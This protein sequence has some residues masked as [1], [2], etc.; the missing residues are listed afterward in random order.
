MKCISRFRNEKKLNRDE[1][2]GRYILDEFKKLMGKE[3]SLNLVSFFDER[4]TKELQYLLLKCT[5]KGVH[6]PDR[7]ISFLTSEINR[8]VQNKII[9]V[10]VIALFV[11]A[12]ALIK[13]FI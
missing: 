9:Y 6:E 5:T 11:S 8:R 12:L 7:A 4:S 3:Y 10:S 2:H 13:S 1:S